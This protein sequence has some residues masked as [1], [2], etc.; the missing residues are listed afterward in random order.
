MKIFARVE[1]SQP[2]VK[3][4]PMHFGLMTEEIN[5]SYDGG[6]YA[7]LDAPTGQ[8]ATLDYSEDP[9]LLFLGERAARADLHLEAPPARR[10]KRAP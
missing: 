5:H 4:G 7:D 1:S 3:I 9:P 6:R 8:F 10:R 2:G